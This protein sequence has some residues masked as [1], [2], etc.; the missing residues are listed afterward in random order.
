M[1]DWSNWPSGQWASYA[2]ALSTYSPLERMIWENLSEGK[3]PQ[4]FTAKVI[5]FGLTPLL[6]MRQPTSVSV[7]AQRTFKVRFWSD[8]FP[9]FQGDTFPLTGVT[10]FKERDSFCMYYSVPQSRSSFCG[11]FL[12]FFPHCRVNIFYHNV[13]QSRSSVGTYGSLPN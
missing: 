11:H 10:H 1:W 6:R 13:S 12:V 3:D 5:H 9:F 7:H 2:S 8:L 4:Q